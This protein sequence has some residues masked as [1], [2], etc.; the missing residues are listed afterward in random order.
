MSQRYLRIPGKRTIITKRM[1]ED[2][3]ENTLSNM[4]ASRWLGVSYNTYKKWSK[5][6]G[7]FEQHLNPSGVGVPRSQINS[8]Y[9][10]DDVLAGKYPDYPIKQLKLRII[11][12]GYLPEECDLCGWNEE[13]LTDKK[14]CLTLDFIDSDSK[15]LKH[16]NLR[17][18]CPNCYFTNVG[19]FKSSRIF[20][21]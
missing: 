1:I 18:L 7:L 3:I 10:L 15:N 2:A 5:Y 6:Y 19:N 12:G 14:V 8:K 4:E 20:C 21:Q 16:E 9:N 13:R 11:K 17:F